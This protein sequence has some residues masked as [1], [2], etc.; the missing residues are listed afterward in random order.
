[1]QAELELE[2]LDRRLTE[3]LEWLSLE[4]QAA[5]VLGEADRLVLA[6]DPLR[7]IRAIQLP[8]LEL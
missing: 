2:R 3:P 7:V 6:V 8:L 1:M 4:P 5:Q